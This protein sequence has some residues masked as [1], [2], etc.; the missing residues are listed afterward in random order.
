MDFVSQRAITLINQ[1]YSIHIPY[2]LKVECFEIVINGI[3]S[4]LDP[5]LCPMSVVANGIKGF[6]EVCK[7]GLPQFSAAH[8]CKNEE[9]EEKDCYKLSSVESLRV[10][11]ALGD[12]VSVAFRLQHDSKK[13]AV[14][15]SYSYNLDNYNK[16]D[17]KNVNNSNK[18]LQQ[19][20]DLKLSI[21]ETTM[22]YILPYGHFAPQTLKKRIVLLLAGNCWSDNNNLSSMS[23]QR[24]A[25]FGQACISALFSLCGDTLL[26]KKQQKYDLSLSARSY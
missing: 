8:K 9:S 26:D 15:S 24:H 1:F 22:R 12:V 18:T 3:K 11:S 23:I 7:T 2:S 17:D 5:F 13:K 21:L 4:I 25:R 6:E 19:L 20:V 14:S 16:I 10:W